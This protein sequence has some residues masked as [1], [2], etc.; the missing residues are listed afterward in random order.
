MENKMEIKR[1]LESRWMFFHKYKIKNLFIISARGS[2]QSTSITDECQ[3]PSCQ[4]FFLFLYKRMPCVA[5]TEMAA[6]N[7]DSHKR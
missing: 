5:L 7:C 6:V 4:H 2:F 3:K 1:I